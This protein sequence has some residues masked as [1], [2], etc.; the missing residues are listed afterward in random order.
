VAQVDAM[1]GGRVE[2]GIGAGWYEREHRAYGLPFPDLGERFDRLT[3]Q[4]EI[5][6]GLWATAGG[7][8][9]HGKHYEVLDS[10]GLPKPVQRPGP[11]VVI[12]GMGARRTPNLAARYAAEYNVAFQSLEAARAQFARV[13][14]AC[15]RVGRDPASMRRSVA[16]VA[17]VGR[18]ETEVARRAAA[19]GRDVEELRANGLAGSPAQVVETVG[20]W[21]EATKIVRV[22]LQVLDHCDLAH[23]ELIGASVLPAFST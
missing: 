18:D 17:C 6:T 11:P 8:T 3:E 15:S 19:I 16:L 21:I 12:G 1:S 10:P 5:V 7:F 20:R 2:F 4:L 23:L 13:D 22:Y 9:F 14:E